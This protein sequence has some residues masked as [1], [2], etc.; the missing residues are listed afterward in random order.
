MRHY[1]SIFASLSLGLACLLA[2]AC[3][4]D[5]QSSNAVSA[6][7]PPTSM[8]PDG[9]THFLKRISEIE[10]LPIKKGGVLLAGDSITEAWLWNIDKLP[11]ETSNHGV[12]W[13]TA[14]GLKARLPLLLKHSPDHVFIL[15]GT[16][17]VA[18]NHSADHVAQN[19]ADVIRTL[20]KEKQDTQIHL[21]AILPRETQSMTL[22]N[23]YNSALSSISQDLGVNFIDMKEAF[24]ASDGT[25][26][27]DL[28]EDGLHLNAQGYTLWAEFLMNLVETSSKPN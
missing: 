2:I 11:F 20:Q 22:V 27:P 10:A 23:A 17:D 3:S 19:V 26:R 14:E 1:F 13:D 12:S 18:Y 28:T 21:Q 4:S 5:V 6:V 16:N 9:Q 7:N 24:A 8:H 25:L 15:I